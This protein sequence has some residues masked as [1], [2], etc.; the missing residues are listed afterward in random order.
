MV[1]GIRIILSLQAHSHPGTVDRTL[2]AVLLRNKVAR[3]KLYAGKRG[4]SLGS[5]AI[6]R[7][8]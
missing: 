7:F 2:L 6:S 8:P 5:P 3:I 4:V 1:D